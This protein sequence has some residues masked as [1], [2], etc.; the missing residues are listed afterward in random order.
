MNLQLENTVLASGEAQDAVSEILSS[1]RIQRARIAFSS[2][3]EAWTL[4]DHQDLCKFY[5]VLDGALC[6]KVDDQS[7]MYTLNTHEFAFVFGTDSVISSSWQHAYEPCRGIRAAFE[8]SIGDM[9]IDPALLPSILFSKADDLSVSQ[10]VSLFVAELDKPGNH[11]CPVLASML[12]TLLLGVLGDSLERGDDSARLLRIARDEHLGPA[13]ALMHKSP[14]D[15]WTLERLSNESGLSRS[16]FAQKFQSTFG[17]TAFAYLRDL[18]LSRAA[19]LLTTSTMTVNQI[20]REVGYSSESAFS[21]AFR[22]F[23]GVAPG[24]YRVMNRVSGGSATSSPIAD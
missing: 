17:K 7:E 9:V 11:A 8:L 5:V 16:S 4:S 3:D 14:G 20:A 15:A 21:S 13:M 24:R 1:L 23:K 2:F 22:D 19:K 10:H 18:R 6:I 12:T